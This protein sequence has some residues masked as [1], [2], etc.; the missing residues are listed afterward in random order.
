[1][2][3]GRFVQENDGD[4]VDTNKLRS[5]E[6]VTKSQDPV[7]EVACY[8]IPGI[9]IRFRIEDESCFP[10]LP[11]WSVEDKIVDIVDAVNI[12]NVGFKQE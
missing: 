1:M 9:D 8:C 4:V 3:N 7:C 11:L 6:C 2:I 5:L 10:S 12:S